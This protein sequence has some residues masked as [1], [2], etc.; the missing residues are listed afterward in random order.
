[1]NDKLSQIA[2]K[3]RKDVEA[4]LAAGLTE[5]KLRMQFKSEA[6]ALS[7]LNR[8]TCLQQESLPCLATEFKRASPSKG[9]INTSISLEGMTSKLVPSL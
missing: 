4:Q 9:P 8:I 3:R 7:L 5:D 2:A 1:M 6:R